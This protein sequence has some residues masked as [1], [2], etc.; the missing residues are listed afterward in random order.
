MLYTTN[1]K[2]IGWSYLILGC[3]MGISGSYLSSVEG[4]DGVEKRSQHII[5]W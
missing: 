4:V 5:P 2:V 1:H 3:L